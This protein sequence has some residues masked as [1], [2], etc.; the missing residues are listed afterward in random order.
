MLVG[1]VAG[2]G[3]K[4]VTDLMDRRISARLVDESEGER[5][6]DPEVPIRA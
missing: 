5:S 4:L 2:L 1:L 3:P 6:G